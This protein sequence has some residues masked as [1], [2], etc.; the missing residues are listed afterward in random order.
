M[1]PKNQLLSYVFGVWAFGVLALQILFNNLSYDLFVGLCLLGF[2]IIVELLGPYKMRLAW[3]SNL[4][5]MIGVGLL[6]FSI[7]VVFNVL[8]YSDIWLITRLF[9]V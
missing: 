9:S 7:I 8:N 2:L 1:V 6:A 5:I 4:N 3:R